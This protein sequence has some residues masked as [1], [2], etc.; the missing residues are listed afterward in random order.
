M[1]IGMTWDDLR[2]LRSTATIDNRAEE[3]YYAMIGVL[4]IV[5][6]ATSKTVRMK[7]AATAQR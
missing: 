1:K 2:V 4:Q 7:S 3:Q 6:R 5:R